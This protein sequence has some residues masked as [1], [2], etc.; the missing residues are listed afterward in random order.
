MFFKS[1]IHFSGHTSFLSFDVRRQDWG[2]I[3]VSG[4]E[5]QTLDKVSSSD[6]PK[7]CLKTTTTTTTTTNKPLTPPDSQQNFSPTSIFNVSIRGAEKT[8][9]GTG[10]TLMLEYAR[11]SVQCKIVF[12]LVGKV[13]VHSIPC[14]GSFSQRGLWNRPQVLVWF[15]DDGRRSRVVGWNIYSNTRSRASRV[16]RGENGVG[17]SSG[18]VVFA[19]GLWVPRFHHHGIHDVILGLCARSHVQHAAQRHQPLQRHVNVQPCNMDKQQLK[20]IHSR[21]AARINSNSSSSLTSSPAAWINN[22]SR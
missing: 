5:R 9:H 14:L 6:W 22:S 18:K 21:P 19:R 16:G 2:E 20:L 7:P 15:T 13:H 1:L 4:T 12:T 3:K 11:R 17:E 8:Q 10:R